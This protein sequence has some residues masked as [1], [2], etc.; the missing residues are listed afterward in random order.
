[1]IVFD[2]LLDAFSVAVHMAWIDLI[3]SYLFFWGSVSLAP[4]TVGTTVTV[5]N[6]FSKFPVRL[7]VTVF[8]V[9]LCNDLRFVLCEPVPVDVWVS[10]WMKVSP[11]E[12]PCRCKRSI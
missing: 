1:M 3:Y 7:K 10:V 2:L 9:R 12:L 11:T 4:C 5:K 6:L 8:L